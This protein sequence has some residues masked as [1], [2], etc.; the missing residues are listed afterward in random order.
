MAYKCPE[1]K[2]PTKVIDTVD[3]KEKFGEQYFGFDHKVGCTKCTISFFF[4]T[5]GKN[6]YN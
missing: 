1:C 2:A 6:P 3:L 5:T 4:R